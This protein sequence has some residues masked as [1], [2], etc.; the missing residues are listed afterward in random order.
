MGGGVKNADAI[1]AYYVDNFSTERDGFH[2]PLYIGE[3]W[4]KKLSEL[5]NKGAV[6]PAFYQQD[7]CADIQLKAI[8]VLRALGTG[9][10]NLFMSYIEQPYK[11]DGVNA[12]LP[13]PSRSTHTRYVA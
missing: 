6:Y 12:P 5:R 1:Y 13:T 3:D 9:Q 11:I 10:Y 7:F 8:E 4:R 2:S